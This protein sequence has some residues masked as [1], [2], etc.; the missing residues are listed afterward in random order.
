MNV[1]VIG[2]AGR[3]GR[4][5]VAELVEH[6]GHAVTI[7]DRVPPEG[8]PVAFAEVDLA[9]DAAL[10]RV[11]AGADV[12]VNTTGPFDLWGA[13][14]LDVAIEQGVHYVDVCDDPAATEELMKRDAAAR[15]AGVRAIVGLGVSPGL[16]NYLGMIAARGLDEVDTVATFWGDSR[17]GMD[18]DAAA[19]HAHALAA[20]FTAGRAAYTHLIMQTAAD[21]PVWRDG[22]PV[23]ERAWR[24]AYRVRASNGETGLYRM[25]GHPEPVTMPRAVTLRDCV[26]IGTVNAGTD[27]LMLPV[28][29][30]V[31]AGEL[32][33]EAAIAEIAAQLT[34]HPQALATPS[35]GPRLRR[36]IGAVATGTAGG[37]A[38]G[39]IVFPGGP[40]DG[41]MS[42]ETAR[43]AVVGVLRI[44]EA[45]AGVH[46]PEGAFEASAFLEHYAAVYWDGGEPY[47]KDVAGPGALTVE[48]S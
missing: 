47:I 11:L 20:A 14:V 13:K 36:L 28:L 35:R 44:D 1:L 32:T 18:P 26:N 22:A 6:S 27:R 5:V 46:A 37:R 34:A 43:P 21:V 25:I 24:T 48:E 4:R 45:P 2:G 15:R 8:S 23:R 31:A 40:V 19:E 3:V 41:S 39:I 38:E 42:L 9:D 12:V 33:P 7:A 10:A 29:D 17:E 30:R 16:T